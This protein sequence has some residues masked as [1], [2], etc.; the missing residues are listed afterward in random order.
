MAESTLDVLRISTAG[1]VDDGKSTLIGRLLFDSKAIPEDQ[2]DA[3]LLA[4]EQT[5]GQPINLALLT[6]GLRAEREQQ[7]TIDV[8]YRYFATAKRRFIIADT[9][10]HA[11][12]TRNM[13]T[14]A[15]TA[16]LAIVLIDARKGLLPQSKR[17]A[18]IASLLRVPKI[19]IAVNKMDLV[20]FDRSVFREIQSQF[21]AF[22]ATLEVEAATFIPISALEG[23]NVVDRSTRMPWYSGPALL[24]FLEQTPRH[25]QKAFNAFR[26]PVQV[27][28]RPDQHFRGF[29]GTVAAGCVEEGDEVLILPSGIRSRVKAILDADGELP[30]AA[31]GDAV[32]VTLT[33]EVDVSRGDMIVQAEKPLENAKAVEVQ[34][35]WMSETQLQINKKYIVAASS[36]E[37]PGYVRKVLYRLDI[38]SLVKESPSSIG[39]N[40]IGSVL[41]TTSKPMH[42]D[43]YQDNRATGSFI[44]IDPDTNVPVAAGMV[45]SLVAGNGDEAPPNSR[46]K[47]EER[48]GHRAL[49]VWLYG[50]TP[51]EAVDVANELETTLALE[52]IRPVV[53]DTDALEATALDPNATTKLLLEQGMVVV[54]ASTHAPVSK[55]IEAEDLFEVFIGS[56]PEAPAGALVLEDF[57]TVDDA[58]REIEQVI[59]LRVAHAYQDY[60]F[61]I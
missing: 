19:V 31:A 49:A 44:L 55:D 27:V 52:G 30:C 48:N 26:L 40:Q 21:S 37:T 41:L 13:V 2:Y 16:D 20:G 36:R 3:I 11:Q 60:T 1:S 9:P 58:V 12:Y 25:S 42:F 18:V 22:L 17:H 35:C 53:L 28:I 46:A 57:T 29:A 8:A 5:E 34:I 43:S 4:S 38:E 50:R 32:V 54:V 6:D 59:R 10:G 15:S 39:L 24:E 56:P 51:Q 47:R 14:G 45:R 33:D 23:D 61:N 7:I